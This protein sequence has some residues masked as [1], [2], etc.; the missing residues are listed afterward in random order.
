MIIF[1]ITTHEQNKYKNLE[2]F[3]NEI[4]VNVYK[5]MV[6]TK[7]TKYEGHLLSKIRLRILSL[8]DRTFLNVENSRKANEMQ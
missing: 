2:Y 1:Y 3:V 6:Q 8:H 4:Q 7:C 5:E